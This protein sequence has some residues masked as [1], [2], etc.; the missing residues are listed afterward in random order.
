MRPPIGVMPN[1]LW[2]EM[3]ECLPPST[4]EVICRKLALVRAIR[5]YEQAR[6]PVNPAWR[7][8]IDF[9]SL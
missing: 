7:L 8:E 5:R 2:I 9:L 4:D 6:L 1:W 3:L